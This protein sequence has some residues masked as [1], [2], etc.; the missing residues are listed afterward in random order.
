MRVCYDLQ[1]KFHDSD[2]VGRFKTMPEA[3]SYLKALV[4]KKCNIDRELRAINS[5]ALPSP[6]Y[7]LSVCKYLYAFFKKG[8]EYSGII[9]YSD[10][11]GTPRRPSDDFHEFDEIKN[12]TEYEERLGFIFIVGKGFMRLQFLGTQ[13]RVN[14]YCYYVRYADSAVFGFEPIDSKI[15]RM[16]ID[17][18]IKKTYGEIP[19]RLSGSFY[20]VMLLSFLEEAKAPRKVSLTKDEIDKLS[21]ENPEDCLVWQMDAELYEKMNSGFI[22]PS[23][24]KLSENTIEDYIESL[25][26]F[27]YAIENDNDG[28]Y[29]PPYICEADSNLILSALR[30]SGLSNDEKKE[31]E[32]K[33]IKDSGMYRYTCGFFKESQEVDIPLPR[34]KD[35]KEDDWKPGDYSLMIFHMLRLCGRPLTI[36]SK[37]N[38]NLQGLIKQYYGKRKNIKRQVISENLTSMMAMGFPIKKGKNGFCFDTSRVLSAKDIN[39]LCDCITESAFDGDTKVRLSSKLRNKFPIGKY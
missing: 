24:R 4:V 29:L 20:N 25:R 19:P 13:N 8:R 17:I 30:A 2:D 36:T 11:E 9:D 35:E 21:S 37:S 28:Y 16:P 18:R 39:T 22:L 12:A 3:C 15:E 6:K 32:E 10:Y 5:S 27:G 38:E 7:R 23:H 33:F 1:A 34:K 26:D 14:T 31:L